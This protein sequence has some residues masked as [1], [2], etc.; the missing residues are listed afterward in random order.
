MSPA[1]SSITDRALTFGP[2]CL[3]RN[4]KELLE[5]E[6]T[7]RLGG[8]AMDLLIALVERAG[9]V[10]SREELEACAWPRTVV[11]ETSLRVHVSALRRALGEGQGGARYI[12]NVPGRGYCFV[13]AVGVA[14]IAPGAGAP[15]PARP[16]HNLPARLTPMVGR[17]EAVD[18]MGELLRRHRLVTVA[19]PGGMGKTTVALALAEVSLPLYEDGVRFVDLAPVTDPRL[20]ASTVASAL[21]IG[22]SPDAPVEQLG[23]AIGPRR[24]LIVLDNCEHV[25]DAAVELA[26]GLLKCV[27]TVSILTTSREP[28]NVDGEWVYRLGSL[29]APPEAAAL[30][31]A[32][33]LAFPAVQ[34]FVQRAMAISDRFELIDEDA[35]AVGAICRRLDG[36]P[37]AIEL[38]A[39]RIDGLGVRG[40]R[41]RLGDPLPLL[42]RGR[43]TAAPRHR[44]LRM[45]LDWSFELLTP[46][47]QAVLC[48]LS[49]FR[50]TFTLEGASAVAAAE[51]LSAAEVVECV[52]GLTVKSLVSAD[53]SG[54]VIRYRLPAATHA[55]ALERLAHAGDNRSVLRRHVKWTLDLAVRSMLDAGR[56]SRAEWLNR[57][58]NLIDDVRAALDWSFSV[59][60]D[61]G[62]GGELAAAVQFLAH[63]LGFEQEYVQRARQ[64]LEQIH[65]LDPPNALLE[66]QLNATLGFNNGFA[67]PAEQSPP[68]VVERALVLA[69]QLGTAQARITA[70][71]AAWVAAYGTG[72]YPTAHAAAARMSQ[73]ARE[74]A[75]PR[76]IVMSDRLVAQ[77]AHYLGDQ[78]VAR[79]LGERVLRH[80]PLEPAAGGATLVPLA[81][82]MR[83]L[84]GR[85]L[86]LEG[87]PDQARTMA[88]E[89]MQLAVDS[90]PLAM[91]QAIC[92]L[93]CPLALWRGDDE[94]ARELIERLRAGSMRL[95]RPYFHAWADVYATVLR[96]RDDARRGGA[97]SEPVRLAP[98]LAANCHPKHLDSAGTLAEE[99]ADEALVRRAEDG[100]AGW[101][102][103]ELLRAHAS[104][105][106]RAGGE[107]AIADA[108]ALY[109]R[110]LAL[111]RSQSALAWELRTAT[112]LG[113]LWLAQGRVDEAK[114]LV[115]GV[116]G[117][118]SEGLDTADLRAAR[119]LLGT[120]VAPT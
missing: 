37:L 85:I 61:P 53:A 43:R 79:R 34:L 68:A 59:L 69:E 118:F 2:F 7:V 108:E 11:E 18:A 97:K 15:G 47:E 9:E 94:D 80:P 17:A 26:T 105:R 86:W 63:E 119:A 113:R 51:N 116:Y 84:L 120:L 1:S 44:T 95:S 72:D 42:T 90:H 76:S 57:Y 67:L 36:M 21:E 16:R 27:A 114:A 70:N 20:L 10:V 74:Q 98:E 110:A 49:V 24:L 33:A 54:D 35:A 8:R 66:L 50:G 81:V 77:V 3:L 31:A 73:L 109:Q 112:S 88:R 62:P 38:A 101:C 78:V 104:N 55:Y 58:S 93:A 65:L 40:L 19:G 106:L 6:R 14:E 46:A 99:L 48:R 100:I 28:L 117:R 52:L 89:S 92:M 12:I 107:G 83:I 13:A 71:Y 5:D 96:A 64:A 29:E 91:T 75:D 41:V 87:C 25:I 32:Q 115:A 111:A 60:G 39:A 30:T 82:S 22:L 56:V 103:P 45:L 102:A 4:R 23:A